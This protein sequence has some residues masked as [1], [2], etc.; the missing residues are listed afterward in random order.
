[1]ITLVGDAEIAFD[2]IG[3]GIAVVF[4]HAFPLNR[5]MWEPQVGAL[6]TECRCITIDFRGFGDSPAVPPYSMDRYA[7]DVAGVL[8]ALQIEQAVIVGLSMGGYVAFA[9]WRRHRHRI[10]GLVLA[11]TRAGADTPEGA[12]K[13]RQMIEVAR[14]QGSTAIANLQ[15]ALLMGATT[16]EKRPDTYD[17]VHRTIAQA[18]VEGIVGALEAMVSRPDSAPTL[19]TINVPTLVIAGEED[20]LIPLSEARA[21]QAG[22][23]GS[24]LEILSQAGHLPNLERP[25]AFNTVITEFL[26][27]LIYN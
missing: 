26:A 23:A 14:S 6:L 10:R 27:S 20:T 19:S 5:T 8:E 13:R 15:I 9:L 3:S 4:L 7:D 1:V 17:A 24:R 21:L 11:D 18:P 22:I 12:S 25:S 2:D 16:R